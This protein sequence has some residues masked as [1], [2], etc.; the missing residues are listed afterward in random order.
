MPPP[1]HLLSGSGSPGG[2]KK[3]RA[4]R[5]AF[6]RGCSLILM[7]QGRLS[8]RASGPVQAQQHAPFIETLLMAAS[9]YG[10]RAGCQSATA[11]SRS[12]AARLESVVWLVAQRRCEEVGCVRCPQH[13][14]D[15]R[16]P[17]WCRARALSAPSA[18]MRPPAGRNANPRVTPAGNRGG[19]DPKRASAL[20]RR[21]CS[22]GPESGPRPKSLITGNL[23]Y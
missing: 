4:I 10:E 19:S 1:I 12:T 20:R 14:V 2:E 5:P 16:R 15:R 22:P 8:C 6:S 17:R 21:G 13:V 18:P 3:R 23:T 7:N 9:M 11:T